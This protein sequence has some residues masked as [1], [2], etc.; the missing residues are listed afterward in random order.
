MSHLQVTKS[1]V[2]INFSVVRRYK[3]ARVQDAVVQVYDYYEPSRWRQET[4]LRS[5][6]A[7][8]QPA[9]VHFLH[10]PA[11]RKATRTYNSDSLRQAD[12]CSFC[13]HGCSRC[14]PGVALTV[15]TSLSAHSFRNGGATC[16][17]IYLLVVVRAFLMV[18]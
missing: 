4:P 1:K 9:H 11:A 2:C 6:Q 10:L 5:S 15:T 13:G 16:S 12:S 3:V 7:P 17:W 8:G 18:L 14:R